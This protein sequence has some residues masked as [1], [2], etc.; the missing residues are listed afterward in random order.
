M[1]VMK[2]MHD[3]AILASKSLLNMECKLLN[4]VLYVQDHRYKLILR[5]LH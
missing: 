1:R 5:F 4:R 2:Y 3:D